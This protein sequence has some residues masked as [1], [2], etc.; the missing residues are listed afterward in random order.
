MEKNNRGR[1]KEKPLEKI[2]IDTEQLLT[3]LEFGYTDV[4]LAKFFKVT[5][6]TIN[7]WKKDPDFLTV[8]KKGKELSD[9]KVERSLY[10]RACGYRHPDVHISNYQGVVTVT[11]IIKY[12]PPDPTSCIFWL[13]NRQSDRW[14]DNAIPNDGND[15][16]GIKFEGWND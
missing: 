11:P 7:N 15:T 8:L 2:P 12:Y 5:E 13:K 9:S 4:Q 16:G 14:R 6:K 3:L 10:E 1:P